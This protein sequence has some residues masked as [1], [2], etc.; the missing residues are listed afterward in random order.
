MTDETCPKCREAGGAHTAFCPD[1][2]K[3][4]PEGYQPIAKNGA[5]LRNP[6]VAG[7]DTPANRGPS[8]RT[9]WIGVAAVV[10]AFCALLVWGNASAQSD[11]DERLEKRRV[12]QQIRRQGGEY[13]IISGM[14]D[15]VA[16]QA[17]FDTYEALARRD[18]GSAAGR[19]A[20]D[21][22]DAAD[23]RMRAVGCYR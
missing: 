19:D 8:E 14:S 9:V 2:D 20:L 1:R 6:S 3:S 4:T 5:L 13:D 10:T 16:L 18:R 7:A 12:D 22:M 15:C 17:R 11:R 21:W 23:D